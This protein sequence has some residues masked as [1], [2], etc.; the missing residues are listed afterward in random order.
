M[1]GRLPSKPV[2]RT[3]RFCTTTAGGVAVE[4]KNNFL[5]LSSTRPIRRPLETTTVVRK[6]SETTTVGVLRATRTTVV[7][8][9]QTSAGGRVRTFVYRRQSSIPGAGA[10]GWRTAR[11]RNMF[12][13]VRRVRR[14]Y[15]TARRYIWNGFQ[16][17]YGLRTRSV[18]SNQGEKKR[19]KR[20][21]AINTTTNNNNNGKKKT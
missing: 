21:S 11:E 10:G 14:R 19:R 18:Q 9:R 17:D 5:T 1:G 15:R 7:C 2:G 8:G 20:T 6:S 12:T 16:R 13:T 3:S 4:T